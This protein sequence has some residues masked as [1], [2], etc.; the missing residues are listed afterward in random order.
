MKL[1]HR[2][3]AGPVKVGGV[4]VHTGASATVQL[5]PALPGAGLCWSV[6]SAGPWPVDLRHAEA[7]P[8][9]TVLVAGDVRVSTPEHVL[10]ALTGL[11]VS[12]TQLVVDGPE[13]PALDG[14]AAAWVAAIRSVGCVDGEPLAVPVV[15]GVDWSAHGGRFVV[16]PGPPERIVHV[17]FGPGGPRGTARWRVGQDPMAFAWARTFVLADQVDALRAAGRGRGATADNTLVWGAGPVERA[18]EPVVHK[19]LDLIG[20]LA[21]VPPVDATVEVWRGSHRLHQEGL[22]RLQFS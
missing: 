21:L 18:E 22:A 16:R 4:G 19:L 2:T 3:L 12:D 5:L 7:V 6:P 15:S 20:D 9:A 14:G 10:A 17:D 13:L 11:G 8:G 1:R